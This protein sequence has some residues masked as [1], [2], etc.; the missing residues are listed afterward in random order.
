MYNA[1]FSQAVLKL[2]GIR[3]SSSG[4]LPLRPPRLVQPTIAVGLV[5]LP[6]LQTHP[7]SFSLRRK[8]K[9]ILRLFQFKAAALKTDECIAAFI[10]IA[11]MQGVKRAGRLSTLREN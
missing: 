7:Q 10:R 9:G 2:P 8:K 6:R 4:I 1:W 5:G 11:V 3:V